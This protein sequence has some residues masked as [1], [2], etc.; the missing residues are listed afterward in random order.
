MQ[1]E[2][3]IIHVDTITEINRNNVEVMFYKVHFILFFEK[4]LSECNENGWFTCFF[5][6][7]LPFSLCMSFHSCT[8]SP[9][10]LDVLFLSY[11]RHLTLQRHPGLSSWQGAS[12]MRILQ[13]ADK[14]PCQTPFIALA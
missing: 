8:L 14:R 5:F 3:C 13:L 2:P 11:P 12:F 1:F 7:P 9:S 6:F 10:Y 4:H